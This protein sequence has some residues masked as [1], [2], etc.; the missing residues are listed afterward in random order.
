MIEWLSSLGLVTAIIFI[1]YMCF[2]LGLVLLILIGAL[3]ELKDTGVTPEAT[4]E[5]TEK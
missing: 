2:V 4:P 5:K 3:H 1:I